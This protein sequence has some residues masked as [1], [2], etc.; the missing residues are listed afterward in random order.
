LTVALLR[1]LPGLELNALTH[2]IEPTTGLWGATYPGPSERLSYQLFEWLF[3]RAGP[4]QTTLLALSAVL[5]ALAPVLAWA[6]LKGA[7]R[8]TLA[9]SLALAVATTFH[10]TAQGAAG[11][12]LAGMLFEERYAVLAWQ[13]PFTVAF[14]MGWQRPRWAAFA[15][16]HRKRVAA[17]A[18]GLCLLSTCAWLAFAPTTP[19]GAAP[20]KPGWEALWLVA[21]GL[22]LAVGAHAVVGLAWPWLRWGVAPLLLPF[23]QSSL[24][25]LLLQLPALLLCL[26]FPPLSAPA[27]WALG[28]GGALLFWAVLRRPSPPRARPRAPHLNLH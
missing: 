26:Q 18:L 27:A 28:S 1:L 6:L 25:A 21:L 9:A 20:L 13:L 8:T 5:L 3:L 11:L 2:W 15:A 19:L 16:Q 22:P 7:H 23:G 14:V 4:A 17:L 24:A 10:P 12:S